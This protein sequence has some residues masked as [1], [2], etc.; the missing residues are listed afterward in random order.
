MSRAAGGQMPVCKPRVACTVTR[1]RRNGGPLLSAATL[2]RQQ[3]RLHLTPTLPQPR[4]TPQ[5]HRLTVRQHTTG[6]AMSGRY[7]QLNRTI[8][9]VTAPYAV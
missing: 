2:D 3:A 9:I 7:A 6:A 1:L 5:I 8:P 4:H